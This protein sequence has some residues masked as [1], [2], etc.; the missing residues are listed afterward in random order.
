MPRCPRFLAENRAGLKTPQNDFY[1]FYLGEK[2]MRLLNAIVGRRNM[3]CILALATA[4]LL[5]PSGHAQFGAA[6]VLGYVHDNSGAVV[7]GAQVTLT[8]VGTNVVVKANTDKDGK[9]EFDSVPIGNYRVTT[10]SQGFATEQTEVFNVAT[11]ARQRVEV[12]LKAGANVTVD[13]TGAAQMLDLDTSSRSTVI[14]TREVENLPLNGRSYADLVLLA[15]GTRR[16]VLE[17][18]TPSSR[19]GAFDIN[20]LRSEWNEFILDG[21][22][23]SNYGTSNQGFENENI[24]PSPDALSE[25][26]LETNNYSAEYGRMPGAVI[27]A[28]TRSGTNQFHGHVWDYI[29]NTDLN[30]AGPIEPVTGRKPSLIKNQF[31]ATLGGPIFKDKVF[32]FTDYEGLREI[33]TYQ[34]APVSLPNAQQRLGHFFYNGDPTKPIP[35]Y[36]P[37]TGISYTNGDISS[38]ATPFALAVLGYLPTNNVSSNPASSSYYTNN[39]SNAPRGTINDDKGD[40]RIDAHFAHWQIFG[41]FSEHQEEIFDPPTVG[42]KS[43]GNANSNVNIQNRQIAGGATWIISQNKLLDFRFAWTRNLGGKT[44]YSAGQPSLLTQY[45]ITDG[46]PTDP[47]LIRTLN[48]QSISGFT[49]LGNQSS[50]PQFQYPSLYN[51]KVNYTWVIPHHSLKFGYEQQ[52]IHTEVN[53][54]NP[55]YGQDNYASKFAAGPAGLFPTCGG[56]VTTN[57]NP[58]ASSDTQIAQAAEVADFLFGNRSSY[59]LTNYTIV[60][61]RQRYFAGYFQDDYSVSPKLT[62]NA[63]LRY[64][65]MTPQWERDNKLANFNPATNSI[66]QASSG[67]IYNRALVHVPMKNFAPRLGFSYAIDPKTALRGG[68]GLVYAQYNREGGENNLTYNGPNVVNAAINNPSPFVTPVGSNLCTSDT[69]NQATCFRQT[70]Q[71]YASGLTSSANFNPLLVTTRYIPSNFSTAYVQSYFL[72]VQRT[73]PWGVMLDVAYVGNTGRRLQIL[74]DYNQAAPCLLATVAL[75]NAAGQ[76]YQARRPVPT[77]GDIEISMPEGSS[78]YNSVQT[79]LEKRVGALQ[80][81]N[82][83]TYSRA[84][85]LSS[86]HLDANNGDNS[87]VNFANPRNDYGPSSYDQ[88]IDNTTSVVWDLPYGHGQHW[89]QNAHGLMNA[90]LGGWQ[91]NLINTMTSGMPFNLT[92]SSSASSSTTAG[93]LFTSDLVTLRPQ[94]ITGTPWRNPKSAF[95]KATNTASL[96][97]YLPFTS[98]AYPSNATYGNTSAYGN[99]SRNKFRGFLY[100]DTDFGL[101]K[102]FALGSDRVKFDFRAELFNALNVTNWAAPDG[103]YSDG[104]GS[105]GAI[106]SFFPARQAQFAGKIIF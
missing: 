38:G 63:G 74:A 98:Y 48:A 73:L 19:E 51:P 7:A 18:G 14:A 81:L 46:L 36:N 49:Q 17:N 8:N 56:T 77:F 5:T 87:R 69:Q 29:R 35:L 16:S 25:F 28:S 89:G 21:L 75:C 83:F 68:Y 92:Y 4:L 58:A 22:E 1:L 45:G 42:G 99:V 96:T 80:F 61:L 79:K 34:L 72:G 88:P 39:Y 50:N 30:A 70:Q 11:D 54:F 103:A 100:F 78:S 97:N 47:K 33:F 60:N 53:D 104:N 12:N 66:I 65:V 94:H 106:G 44:P 62:I 32:F 86:G 13:V 93:P 85:D 23:N 90:V 37:I 102:Q 9:F 40:G 41:R 3:L 24:S 52:I 95:T 82:S 91:L 64:E 43:G 67:S 6:S 31:G 10:S 105:F 20:G 84:F 27:N 71:G 26:R 101:H 55:S 76:T 2:I 57:C 15:P 59:S